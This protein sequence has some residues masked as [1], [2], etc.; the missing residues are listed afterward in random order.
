MGNCLFSNKKRV[1]TKTRLYDG[2]EYVK[3]IDNQ[4]NENLK[5][6]L[7]LDENSYHYPDNLN[8]NQN[9]VE[10]NNQ[11]LDELKESI[12]SNKSEITNTNNIIQMIEKNSTENMRLLSEDIHL[13]HK[14]VLEYKNKI[15]LMDTN[16]QE[17]NKKYDNLLLKSEKHLEET[18]KLNEINRILVKKLESS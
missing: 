11:E 2:N 8:Q 5:L 13:I 12:T 17:L 3:L 14:T 16:Y 6:E 7:E 1:I 4:D 18:E 9:Y 10:I 15:V